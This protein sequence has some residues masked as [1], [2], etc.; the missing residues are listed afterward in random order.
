MHHKNHIFCVGNGFLI[1]ELIPI[2]INPF[3][4]TT[5]PDEF[6]TFLSSAAT[7]SYKFIIPGDFNMHIDNP[8]DSS[9][10]QYT[11]LLSYI[12]NNEIFYNYTCIATKFY[13]ISHRRT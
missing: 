8:L 12:K 9:S 7:T 13:I 2:I 3:H 6:Q 1:Q 5:L 10:Q 4:N 11:D